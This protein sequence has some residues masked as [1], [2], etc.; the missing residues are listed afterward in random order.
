MYSI[1]KTMVHQD[2]SAI[3]VLLL[4]KKQAPHGQLAL[5]R[6][7]ELTWDASPQVLFPWACAL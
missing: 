4:L 2:T 6:L 5:S 3:C 1:T 7:H